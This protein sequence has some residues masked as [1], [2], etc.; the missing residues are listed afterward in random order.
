MLGQNRGLKCSRLRDRGFKI[1]TKYQEGREKNSSATGTREV[2]QTVSL[3][4][5][6]QPRTW[7]WERQTQISVFRDD[8]TQLTPVTYSGSDLVFIPAGGP[9]EVKLK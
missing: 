2:Q 8:M 7:T 3:N 9:K 4:L 5:P 1:S 6:T